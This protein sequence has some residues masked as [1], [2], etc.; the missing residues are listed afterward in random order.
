VA[1][2]A[3]MGV[4]RL[5]DGWEDMKSWLEK[6]RLVRVVG[7]RR[8]DSRGISKGSLGWRWE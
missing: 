7:V 2:S 5:E 6:L 8:G 3:G 4:W 1:R